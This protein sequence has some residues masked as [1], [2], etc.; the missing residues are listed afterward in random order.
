MSFNAFPTTSS[1]AISLSS[2]CAMFLF[3]TSPKCDVSLKTTAAISCTT[4]N[5]VST[6]NNNNTKRSPFAET[7]KTAFTFLIWTRLRRLLCL[8][9][10]GLQ[11]NHIL[12]KR[13]I[14]IRAQPSLNVSWFLC[15]RWSCGL[16]VSCC[17]PHLA[18]PLNP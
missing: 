9:F 13:Y 7:P 5:R 4:W 17:F 2:I 16:F 15:F 6:N 8:S 14:Y 1:N 3:G 11:P 18:N 12:R 10:C